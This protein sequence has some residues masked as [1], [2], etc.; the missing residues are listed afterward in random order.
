MRPPLAV[1]ARED[2][3]PVLIMAG[4]AIR[5]GI[6]KFVKLI[7]RFTSI[8]SIQERTKATVKSEVRE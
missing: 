5:N 1:Y 2:A 6:S 8:Y 3:A 7:A 4:P